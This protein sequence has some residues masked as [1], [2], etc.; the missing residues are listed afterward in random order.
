MPPRESISLTHA[1]VAAFLR[2]RDHMVLA[3]LRLDG[4]PDATIVTTH[5]DGDTLLVDAP[6]E[7]RDAVAGDDRVC[8]AAEVCPSYYEIKGVAV[9]G[10]AELDD[11]RLRVPIANATS[12]DFAR[13]RERP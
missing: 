8:C 7:I 9:H 13:I 10:R 4:S 11:G 6:P 2:T 3:M 12:F 1:E 5:L